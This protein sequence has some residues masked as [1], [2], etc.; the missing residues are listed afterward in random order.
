MSL[1]SAQTAKVGKKF[2]SVRVS[3]GLTETDA[4]AKTLINSDYIKAIESGDYS[5][6]P[7]RM[8]ALKYFEKYSLFLDIH[9]VFYDIYNINNISEIDSNNIKISRVKFSS[10][11]FIIAG[12]SLLLIS[13]ILIFNAA[14]SILNGNSLPTEQALEGKLLITSA[15]DIESIKNAILSADVFI[16]P[17]VKDS[18]NSQLYEFK[19]SQ[20][21][22]K[23]LSL[24]F[25]QDSWVEIYQ[26]SNQLIYKLFKVDE[27]H[28]MA[29]APPFKIV[30]NKPNGIVGY[31]GQNEIYF[32]QLP[33][34][35]NVSSIEIK[36]E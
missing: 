19:A 16:H 11:S 3:L 14:I 31:Y 36:N 15:K 12:I 32:T 30:T 18:E 24:E 8:F 35:L 4:S 27:K 28:E 5:I 9:P 22:I 26:G 21:V 2:K 10:P 34:Q 25:T 29:M 7:A 33:N 20:G 6:F 13:L 1:K 17:I 23:N